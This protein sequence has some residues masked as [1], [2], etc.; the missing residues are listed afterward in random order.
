[1]VLKNNIT[2][3]LIFIML[4]GGL[5]YAGFSDANIQINTSVQDGSKVGKGKKALSFKKGEVIIKLKKGSTKAAVTS[6]I[7]FARDNI[8][9]SFKILSSIKKQPY[10]LIK[11]KKLSIE[12]LIEKMKLDPNI[13][14]VEP[15]YIYH[16]DTVPNDPMFDLLWGE[17]NTG[18]AVN[19]IYGT[20]DADMDAP[21]AWNTSTGSGSVVVAVIDTGVDYL[22]EDL[23]G[24][25]WINPS[26]IPG[27]GIDDDGNGYIDDIHGIN[28]TDDSGDP[29]ETVV[30]SGGHGTHVAGAIAAVGD[31]DIG[32]AGVSWKAKIMALKFISGSTGTTA[33]AIK[34]LE[35]VIAQKRAG[36]NIVAANASWGGGGFSQAL[37]DTIQAANDAGILFVAS[38]GNAGGDTDISPHYPSSFDLPG[39]ISVAASDQDDHLAPWSNYGPA[40]IDLSAPGTNMLSTMPRSPAAVNY[41]IFY[42]DMESGMGKWSTGGSKN[43]WAVATDQELF[44]NS[45]YPIPSPDHFLSDSPGVDYAPDTD[46][47]VMLKDDIDLSAY[48]SSGNL[49]LD[50]GSAIQIEE[51]YDHARVEVSGDGGSTWVELFDFSGYGRY[52]QSPYSFL[53]P[54]AVKTAHF[55]VRFHLTSDSGAE[56]AGWLIDNVGIGEASLVSNYGYKSGTSMATPQVVG[57]VA[58]LASINTVDA[59]AMRKARILDGVDALSDLRGKVVTDGRLNLK[60]AVDTICP[61]G[62]HRRQGSWECIDDT[63]PDFIPPYLPDDGGYIQGTEDPDPNANP[64]TPLTLDLPSCTDSQKRLIQ[65]TDTCE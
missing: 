26:E 52:W 53:L 55:R 50:I 3:I 49:V 17:D 43:T 13:K 35:Y 23:A 65:G 54:D 28:A 11:S 10:L 29:M 60:N 57:A 46:S 21:E 56:E 9:K 42:D 4:S 19:G 39:I 63:V 6:A 64:G 38:A 15:N 22:H 25:M 33:D 32:I 45:N 40:S 36:V 24:N 41:D 30:E 16:P 1:M 2:T 48:G 8:V 12:E 7:P 18:Q 31:N 34:C 51:E 61:T 44:E 20:I 37:R 14:S 62:Q 5:V 27:N 47:W 59:P 58:I